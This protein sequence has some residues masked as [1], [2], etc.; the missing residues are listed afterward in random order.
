M[1]GDWNMAHLSNIW[2]AYKHIESSVLDNIIE[3][4]CQNIEILQRIIQIIST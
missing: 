1:G 2:R 3:C 4:E